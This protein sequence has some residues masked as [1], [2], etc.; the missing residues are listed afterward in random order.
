MSRQEHAGTLRRELE[1]LLGTG[2]ADISESAGPLVR[3]SGR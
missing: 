3:L 2:I 1:E